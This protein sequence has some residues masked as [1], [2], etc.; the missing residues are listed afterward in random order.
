MKT[1]ISVPDAVFKEA[2]QLAG[3]LGL[4]RSALYADAVREYIISH[5]R[6]RVTE[7]LDRA[8]AGEPARVDDVLATM[9]AATVPGREEW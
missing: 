7:R 3:E 4:S 1:A 2:E 9:Q 5:S 6:T 8:Y